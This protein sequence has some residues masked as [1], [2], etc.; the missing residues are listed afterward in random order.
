LGLRLRWGRSNCGPSNPQKPNTSAARFTPQQAEDSFATAPVHKLRFIR[1]TKVSSLA[2]IGKEHRAFQHLRFL[3]ISCKPPV[4]TASNLHPVTSPEPNTS[5]ARFTPQQAEDSFATT[6]VHKLQLLR[7]TK[8][9]SSARIGKQF[10]GLTASAVPS[11]LLQTARLRHL[12]PSPRHIAQKPNTSESRFTPQ[13]AEDSFATTPVHKLQLLRKTKVRSSARIG[14]QFQGLTASAVPSDLLQTARP[15]S[16]TANLH[17]VT[18][19]KPNTSAA[20]FTPQQAE[21]SFAA[22]PVHKLQ[23]LQ[24]TKVRVIAPIRERYRPATPA[25]RRLTVQLPIRSP[26]P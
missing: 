18:S 19:P 17:P 22:T 8:V 16:A 4:S 6:P 10:Q 24:K 9:R 7:K 14:K 13:Q 11:D 2:R 21:D 12:E 25:G 23:L 5:A 15:G 26:K 1:I 20:R 3:Q